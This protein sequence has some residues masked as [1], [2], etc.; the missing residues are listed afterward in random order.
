MNRTDRLYALVEELRSV[1][2]DWRTAK[3]FAER[4]EVSTRTIERD[5][6]ALQQAG[7][8]IFATLGRRGGY[9]IDVK[10]TLPPLN[11]S[12]AEVT[13]VATALAAES[14]T[15]FTHAGRSAL[16]PLAVLGVQPHWYVWGWCR[17]R[18]DI[19]A[20]R[21]DRIS[22]AAIRDESI[23]DRGFDPADIE[24]TDLISRGILGH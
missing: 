18:H 19:R 1:A 10:H 2:P 23:P 3:W 21:L 20:F 15:P 22:A 16:A 4:F 13:A 8:P 9:A 6:S 24:L 11:L 14:A 17:L 12:A 5:L 7:V